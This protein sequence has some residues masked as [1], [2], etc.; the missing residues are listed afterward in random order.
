MGSPKSCQQKQKQAR[1]SNKS[2]L[3][4]DGGMAV[5]RDLITNSDG[6]EGRALQAYTD[7][8]TAQPRIERF[9]TFAS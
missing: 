8:V 7:E 1:A 5:V 4:D 3:L 6:A 2:A 9:F